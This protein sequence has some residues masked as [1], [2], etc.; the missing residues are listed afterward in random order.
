[1]TGVAQLSS[2]IENSLIQNTKAIRVERYGQKK[3]ILIQ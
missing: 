2:I 3:E 1:M